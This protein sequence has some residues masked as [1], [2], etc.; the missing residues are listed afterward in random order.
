MRILE[1]FSGIGAVA[2]AAADRH[3]IVCAIDIS[4]LAMQVYQANFSSQTLI[5]EITSLTDQQLAEFDAQLWWM[6]PPCQPFTRRGLQRDLNDPR[7]KPLL[8]LIEAIESVRPSHIAME[9]VIGFERSETFQLLVKVLQRNN[10]Q[11]SHCKLCSTQF[12]LPNLR[13]RFHDS[14][15][16]GTRGYPQFAS[17][18]SEYDDS[19]VG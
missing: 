12:G 8:R 9:N 15:C 3:D 1:L 5:Q 2:H 11:F 7:A 16:N 13:P 17:T 14:N 4:E 10:Y 19:T 18:Q 6:S